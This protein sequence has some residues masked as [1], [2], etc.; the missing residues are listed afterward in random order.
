MSGTTAAKCKHCGRAIAD[1]DERRGWVHALDH[2]GSVLG[3]C[4]PDESGLPYGYDAEPEGQPCRNPCLG[5]VGGDLGE[6][7]P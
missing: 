4:N 7:K 1:G 3:R 2:P 5:S 6:A